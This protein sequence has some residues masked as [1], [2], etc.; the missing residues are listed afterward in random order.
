MRFL[1]AGSRSLKLAFLPQ[2][3]VEYGVAAKLLSKA[4]R[5][6]SQPGF[7]S[8][9]REPTGLKTAIYS[10]SRNTNMDS[11]G[12]VSTSV[13]ARSSNRVSIRIV[14]KGDEAVKRY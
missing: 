13:Y 14:T 12:A 8:N 4:D 6:Y 2:Y 7:S 1:T 9:V 10:R 3:L 5:N 11:S